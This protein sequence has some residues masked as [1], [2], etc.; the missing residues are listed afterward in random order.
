MSKKFEVVLDTH[1]L[2]LLTNDEF[3]EI[4]RSKCHTLVI[5]N[6]QSE[7][8]VHRRFFYTIRKKL[9]VVLRGKFIEFEEPDELPDHVKKELKKCKARGKD[10]IV[11]GVAIRR[12]RRTGRPAIIVSNDPAF[13]CARCVR[14]VCVDDAIECLRGN[15]N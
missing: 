10:P 3:I 11:A 14:A 13:H 4:I 9:H 2:E 15:D 7:I 5:P 1:A 6:V 12:E 8:D